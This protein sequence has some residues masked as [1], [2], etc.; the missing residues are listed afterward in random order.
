MVLDW[1]L[2][3][4][5]KNWQLFLVINLK[6]EI[7][8]MIQQW[9]QCK[10]KRRGTLTNVWGYDIAPPTFPLEAHLS[11]NLWRIGKYHWFRYTKPLQWYFGG[12]FF[13]ENMCWCASATTVK[14]ELSGKKSSPSS[15]F[16]KQERWEPVRSTIHHITFWLVT[17]FCRPALLF[18]LQVNKKCYFF[19]TIHIGNN[20]SK[21]PLFSQRYESAY[22]VV[23]LH[24]KHS[25][26]TRT[27][28]Y[29][30]LQ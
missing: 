24:K 29:R 2:G 21:V 25:R 11:H 28:M 10:T 30:P 16:D 1:I 14:W 3:G 17:Q 19:Q 15:F 26:N 5:Y 12:L 6:L 9:W 22:W 27:T 7:S 8:Q 13:F 23:L 18:T 4:G 20:L